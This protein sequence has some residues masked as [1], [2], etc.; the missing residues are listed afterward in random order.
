MALLD[1]SVEQGVHQIKHFMNHVFAQD[2]VGDLI[3]IKLRSLQIESGSG[4]HLLEA[5]KEHI[6]YLIP[7]WITS[8]HEFLAKNDITMEYTKVT[9]ISL[10]R[11]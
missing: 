4:L 11:D 3:M 2:T 5:P 1:M 6:S 10:S 7:S 8:L 9:I